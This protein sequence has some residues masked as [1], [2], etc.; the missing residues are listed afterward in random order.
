MKSFPKNSVLP[1]CALYAVFHTGA[2]HRVNMQSSPSAEEV[3]RN[4]DRDGWCT[5]G[6]TPLPISAFTILVLLAPVEKNV[7]PTTSH[8]GHCTLRNFLKVRMHP[9]RGV[10]PCRLANRR[11]QP[12][13]YHAQF[14]SIL[15]YIRTYAIS[16]FY[17]HPLPETC[18]FWPLH[19][20]TTAIPLPAPCLRSRV[21]PVLLSH[22][23]RFQP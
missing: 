9:V 8:S 7:H 16:K 15:N 18:T 20:P 12:V 17:S 14:L 4:T 3:A 22:Y 19:P 5:P 13:V 23:P 1:S 11:T 10:F 2:F 21:V 6:A